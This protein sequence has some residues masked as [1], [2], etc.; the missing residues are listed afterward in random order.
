MKSTL[1]K[2]GG[3]AA[4]CALGISTHAFAAMDP[5]LENTLIAV[6]KAGA[7]NSLVSFNGTMKEYRIN[8]ARIFPRLVCNGENFHQF[9]LSQGAEKTAQRIGRYVQGQV[10]IKD[11]TANTMDEVYAVNF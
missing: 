9:A 10:T 6:C 1:A 7:S 11:I 3:I 8:E 4:F 5:Q 2:L